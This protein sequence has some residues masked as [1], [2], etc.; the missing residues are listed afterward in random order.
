MNNQDKITSIIQKAYANKNVIAIIKT[1]AEWDLEIDLEV[2]SR[3]DV[4]R[5]MMD[6][7]GQFSTTIKDYDLLRIRSMP[8]YN[9]YPEKQTLNTTVADKRKRGET[10][11]KKEGE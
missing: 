3:Q 7:T 1:L 9:F 8:K 6:L 5:F 11:L 10:R 4:T 2:K